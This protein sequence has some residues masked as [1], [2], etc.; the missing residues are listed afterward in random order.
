MSICFY[1]SRRSKRFG[2]LN[3]LPDPAPLVAIKSSGTALNKL[4]AAIRIWRQGNATALPS[5]VLPSG[6]F[7]PTIPPRAA[8]C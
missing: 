8:G 2:L 7:A 5:P 6:G 4:K 3:Y 1:R